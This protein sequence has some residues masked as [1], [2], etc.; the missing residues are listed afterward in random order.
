MLVKVPGRRFS[1]AC[2]EVAPVPHPSGGRG[3]REGTKPASD[4]SKQ[5]T[6]ERGTKQTKKKK[7]CN[8]SVKACEARGSVNLLDIIQAAKCI[9][10]TL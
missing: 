2:G 9:R 7:S 4:R 5:N 10:V 6:G 8:V 1:G 3:R